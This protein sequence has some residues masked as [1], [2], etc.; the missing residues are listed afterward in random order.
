M[1]HTV[2]CNEF[3]L[4]PALG[5]R[6]DALLT[7]FLPAL[8]ALCPVYMFSAMRTTVVCQNLV[9]LGEWCLHIYVSSWAGVPG[10]QGPAVLLGLLFSTHKSTDT[11]PLSFGLPGSGQMQPGHAAPGLCPVHHL[12][13]FPAFCLPHV[14]EMMTSSKSPS[15]LQVFPFSLGIVEWDV[16]EW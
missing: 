16:T 9:T 14:V 4:S 1:S 13:P 11:R 8:L 10:H 7:L 2:C 6:L 3:P 5:K 12:F 15:H